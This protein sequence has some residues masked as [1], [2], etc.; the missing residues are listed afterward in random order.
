MNSDI[1]FYVF[2]IQPV[3]FYKSLVYVYKYMLVQYK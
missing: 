1:K 3:Y 2:H